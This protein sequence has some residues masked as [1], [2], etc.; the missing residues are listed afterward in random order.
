MPKGGQGIL[1]WS[2][3][4]IKAMWRLIAQLCWDTHRWYSPCFCMSL[5]RH[6]PL[7][8]RSGRGACAWY[9]HKAHTWHASGVQRQ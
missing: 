5:V 4:T 1:L 6:A 2:T 9:G 8:L 3:S 7:C